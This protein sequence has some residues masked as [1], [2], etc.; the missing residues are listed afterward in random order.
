MTLHTSCYI[1]SVNVRFNQKLHIHLNQVI[2]FELKKVTF[3]MKK[4]CIN[5]RQIRFLV[6]SPVLVLNFSYVHIKHIQRFFILKTTTK[7]LIPATRNTFN[8]KSCDKVFFQSHCIFLHE[9]SSNKKKLL[10]LPMILISVSTI[11]CCLTFLHEF[12]QNIF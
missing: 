1:L 12:I 3:Q 6:K 4:L 2:F 8:Q 9:Q 5:L 7:N 11:K 10:E